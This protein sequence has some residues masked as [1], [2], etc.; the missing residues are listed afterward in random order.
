MINFPISLKLDNLSSPFR[1]FL[2]PLCI[3]LSPGAVLPRTILKDPPG[4]APLFK[5]DNSQVC[6]HLVATP[7]QKAMAKKIK[8][9]EN[10]V[11]TKD[12]KGNLSLVG[13]AKEALT[14]FHKM[15]IEVTIQLYEFSKEAAEKLLHDNNVPYTALIENGDH[16][17]EQYDICV[18]GGSNVIK[19][20]NDWRW[21]AEDVIRQLYDGKRDKPLSEQQIMDKSLEEIKKFTQ[22]RAKKKTQS[23]DISNY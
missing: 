3:L 8:L 11:I 23:L 7:K 4:T 21:T 18:V 22:E 17:K 13:K 6:C 15:K 1:S 14:S 5:K 16:A 12:D 19:L 20:G 10:T 9:S 2:L